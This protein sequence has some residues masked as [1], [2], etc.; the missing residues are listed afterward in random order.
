MKKLSSKTKIII[1]CVIIFIGVLIFAIYK[2]IENNK[3]NSLPK[4]NILIEQYVTWYSVSDGYAGKV[5]YN[6]GSVYTFS[7]DKSSDL[8]NLSLEERSAKIRE[9]GAKVDVK[10]SEEDL[11]KIRKYINTLEDRFTT[12]LDRRDYQTVGVA[13]YKYSTNKCIKI[14]QTGEMEGKNKT[15]KTDE[16]IEVLNKY[17]FADFKEKVANIYYFDSET[18]EKYEIVRTLDVIQNKSTYSL[19]YTDAD[20]K[21]NTKEIQL[22][23]KEVEELI[24][25]EKETECKTSVEDTTEY[26]Y[27]TSKNNKK[28]LEVLKK[29]KSF[30]TNLLS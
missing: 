11:L 20:G 22:T 27:V 5:I 7:F 14:V 6:D 1:T 2:L 18:N 29:S 9:V 12:N 4:E 28:C 24:E 13:G 26:Y 10:V 25:S 8:A 30:F 16:I 23:E 15:P 17:Q 3:L 19:N 21:T